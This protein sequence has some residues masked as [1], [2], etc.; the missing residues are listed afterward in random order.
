MSARPEPDT[1]PA[2][3]DYAEQR[4]PRGC[5]LPSW[6]WDCPRCHGAGWLRGDWQDTSKGKQRQ[7]VKCPCGIA[8]RGEIQDLP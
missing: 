1:E 6:A 3:Y 7:M 4:R 2:A 8:R 5:E